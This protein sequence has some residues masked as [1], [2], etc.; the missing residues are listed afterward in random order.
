MADSTDGQLAPYRERLLIDD[1]DAILRSAR[2]IQRAVVVYGSH[3]IGGRA[4]SHFTDVAV[5]QIDSNELVLTFAGG[6]KENDAGF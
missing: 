4:Q 1:P 2:D 3:V 5:R 6:E